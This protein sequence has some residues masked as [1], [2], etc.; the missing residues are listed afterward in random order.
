MLA[1]NGLL[2][3]LLSCFAGSLLLTMLYIK[4]AQRR[5]IVDYPGARRMHHTITPRGGGIGFVLVM[6]AV[7]C[8]A[9]LWAVAAALIVVAGVSF[10]DDLW[11]LRARTRL[12]AHSLAGLVFC[13]SVFVASLNHLTTTLPG[14]IWLLHTAFF[15]AALVALVWSINLHNFIDGAN[16]MLGLSALL[17]LVGLALLA[18]TPS[19]WLLLCAAALAGFLPWNFPHARVFMGDV[20]ATA[21]GLLIGVGL[22]QLWPL[23]AF[24]L[25][26]MLPSAAVIDTTA[27]LLLRRSKTKRW[28]TA[29][30]SHLYQWLIRMGYSHARVSLLYATWTLLC[31][32][33]AM[34]LKSSSLPMA[35]AAMVTVYGSGFL[36]WLTLRSAAVRRARRLRRA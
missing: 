32:L 23:N 11:T 36:L 9:K 5:Q 4:V 33:L 16:G 26:L 6:L 12:A 28:Y 14:F 35:V 25:A 22:I 2:L 7:L 10:A 30:R 27:T 34:M 29:H 31:G 3:A 8:W 17:V 24:F 15:I 1:N 21:L 13:G 20:G 19:L 18:P